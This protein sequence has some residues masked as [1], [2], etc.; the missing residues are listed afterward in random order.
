MSYHWVKTKKGGTSMHIFLSCLFVQVWVTKDIP[1][2]LP[3]LELFANVAMEVEVNAPVLG[4]SPALSLTSSAYLGN[5]IR[6]FAPT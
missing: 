3:P 5:Y 1:R 2:C 6:I 4:P